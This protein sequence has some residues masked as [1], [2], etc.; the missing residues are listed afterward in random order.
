MQKYR[1]PVVWIILI[2]S[3]FIY[4]QV[5]N[6]LPFYSYFS[7]P[8]LPYIL[9]SVMLATEGQVEHTDH[10]GTILQMVGAVISSMC[11]IGHGEVFDDDAI[12]LFRSSWK[13]LSLA[14]TVGLVVFFWRSTMESVRGWMF[15]CLVALL[16]ADYN[17]LVFWGT[18]T[19]EGAFIVLY[20]PVLALCLRRFYSS[21]PMGI[22]SLVGMGLI[23]GTA[24]TMK[25][26][27][28]PATLFVVIVYYTACSGNAR[29][30]MGRTGLLLVITV[31]SFL[32]LGSAFAADRSAQW[33][34][35]FALIQNS[36]RYGNPS[37]A[38][39]GAFLSFAKI[40]SLTISG[41]KLQNFATLLPVGLLGWLGLSDAFDR[42]SSHAKRIVAVAFLGCFLLSWIV[43]LKH[44]YQIK[45][46]L[47]QTP[48]LVAFWYQRLLA[49]S[50]AFP[51]YFHPVAVILLMAVLMTSVINYRA[52]HVVT[53]AMDRATRPVIDQAVQALDPTML[54]FSLEVRHP[55]SAKAFALR[56]AGI[57][58]DTFREK[59]RP[60][61]VFRERTIQYETTPIGGIPIK[62]PLPGSMVLTR[63]A[64][65]DDRFR[66]VYGDAEAGL[67]IY[68]HPPKN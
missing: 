49:G 68:L 9:N 41:L 6:P 61:Q 10:P 52:V 15:A 7:D 35:I 22:F 29:F 19:P 58:E 12:E 64:F 67:H 57:F 47:V 53:L 21:V 48:L 60:A 65:G 3:F 37:E 14:L 18:F 55:L 17:A 5:L 28:W 43:F 11:G 38:E 45:Y 46:L 13:F 51:K 40:V 62:T 25:L 27:L 24:T 36:G 44:P 66:L 26:T 56:E 30:R 23:L 39:P 2:A 34:W 4:Y 20:I 54:Y 16:F 33:A 63:T 50:R 42:T 32:L 31:A 1:Q 59:V 8:E